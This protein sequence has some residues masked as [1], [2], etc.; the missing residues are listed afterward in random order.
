[1]LSLREWLMDLS[2]NCSV[3]RFEDVESGTFVARV[4]GDVYL[5]NH[6]EVKSE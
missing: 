1:M 2:E 3:Q 5:M 6:D 4:K